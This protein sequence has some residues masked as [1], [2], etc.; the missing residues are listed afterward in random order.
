VTTCP[1]CRRRHLIAAEWDELP[2]G[3]QAVERCWRA[4]SGVDPYCRHVA[5]DMRRRED[6]DLLA[7]ARCFPPG[8]LA[9]VAAILRAGAE[10]HG[11]EPHETG[12]DQSCDDH[13]QHL[14]G[15]ALTADND[16]SAPGV[17]VPKPDPD[18]G[19]SQFA[20]VGARAALGWE[21]E[22]AVGA[23]T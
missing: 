7:A 6:A 9:E 17:A 19:R 1:D 15:H 12:G 5:A 21:R 13:L 11:C 20:H 14:L 2:D 16:M 10:R 4:V 3:D 8:Y 22:R 23:G 18:S